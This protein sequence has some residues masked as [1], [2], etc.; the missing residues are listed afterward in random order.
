MQDMLSKYAKLLVDYSLYLKP[1]ETLYINSTTVAIPLIKEIYTLATERQVR[2]ETNLDFEDKDILYYENAEEDL[3]KTPPLFHKLAMEEVDAYLFIRAPYSLSNSKDIDDEKRKLRAQ[4]MQPISQLYFDRTASG[5]MKRSLCQYPT[6]ANAKMANMS[7][8]EYADFVF[9]ACKLNAENPKAAWEE[10]SKNQQHIVDYLNQSSAIRYVNKETDIQFSVKGRTWINSDGKTNMPS[11]E[12]FSSPV[13]DTVNGHIYFENP[14]VYMG[15]EVSGI[16]L[17]VENGEVKEWQAETGQKLL[18][19]LLEIPGSRRFGEVAIGTNY[20]IQT[21]TKN[22]LFDE[23][24]G[25]TVH[26]AIGQSYGQTGGKNKS[27]IHWDMICN[28]KQDAAIYA[29]D[30]MIYENGKFL[31]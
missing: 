20:D 18:D 24:M 12:V 28:M 8:E 7:V 3:L 16:R 22:I 30:K 21:P 27:A 13:E 5:S 9:T 26:M 4:A 1:K 29:D 11:G 31:I 15:Q 17:K 2:V 23:K 19:K 14:S 10:L 6:Q 25:G